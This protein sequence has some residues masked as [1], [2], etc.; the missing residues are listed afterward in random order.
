M[1]THCKRTAW[2][3]SLACLT[4]MSLA[5][6]SN[7][8]AAGVDDEIIEIVVT[9]QRRAQR[10]LLHPGNIA[11]LDKATIE[12]VQHQ[13]IN[14]LLHRVPGAWVVR[15]SGQEH[16]TAIR[17]P[18]LGGGGSCGGFLMLE[19][20]IPIR[21]ASFCNVNQLIEVNA[22]QATSIEVVR[23]PANALHG[24]NALHGVVNVLMPVP[25]EAVSGQM[26]LELGSNNFARAR[27][28]VPFDA[29]SKWLA[30]IIY[31]HDGGFRDDSGYRQGKLHVKRRWSS[32]EQDFLI[33]VTA[34]DLMQDSAGFIVGEDAYKNP[35]LSRTN[36]TPE[37]FRDAT[38]V[39]L[40]GIW[41][42]R[43]AWANL[44]FRP[45]LRRSRMEFM[46]HGLPG[47]PIEDNGQTSAGIISALTYEMGISQVIVGLDIEW[48]DA[49]LK[50]NQAQPAM[51]PPRQSETRPV[52][53]HY[54]YTVESLGAALFLQADLQVSDRITLGG[55]LRA[56]YL[57]NDYRNHMLAGNTRDDG[58]PCG[59]GGCLYSRPESRSDDFDNLAPNLSAVFQLNPNSSFYASIA[60]GFR[61]PQSLELYRLQNGQQLADLESERTDS[62]ELGV[63]SN[64]ASV[65]MD[66]VAYLMRKRD[67]VFRDSGGFNV[68]GARSRHRGIEASMQWQ[69]ASAL[70]INANASYAR[71]TY[72]FDATGPG[73]SFVSGNDIDTAPRLLGSLGLSIDV[74][75]SIGFGM[76]WLAV[77]SYFLEPANRF[78]YDGH[79]IA[80]LRASY[81]R[82]DQFEVVIR[83]NN[84]FD[85]RYADRADHAAGNFR[86]LPGR[87][88][89]FFAEIRHPPN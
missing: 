34:T 57:H 69:V 59:F 11:V 50:Q 53:Q 1:W 27:F 54:D 3:A 12:N 87:G 6:T 24:S 55:G 30:S 48:S 10:R 70:H 78:R 23:G 83:V 4:L 58:T 52:G 81:R 82:G 13:H 33:A 2:V 37:A 31:A 64:R 36:P 56:E 29:G 15:G 71:H 35:E 66:V 20:N 65:H 18:V 88:R 85:E 17:S 77:G 63:R 76:Q 39:R 84:V 89:E 16:Q 26:G 49:F 86:Y 46:H 42:R 61:V 75:E 41:E 28:S 25:G 40:Y 19:D 51:G 9:S 67:S 80:N 8:N 47:N 44:D 5:G 7:V 32:D 21:P 73:Q 72:D 43:L 22:E 38:S 68:T 45:Y 14:E 79:V 62:V 60:R 74:S